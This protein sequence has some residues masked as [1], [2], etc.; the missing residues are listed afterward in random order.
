[1]QLTS[2]VI[3]L[4][5]VSSAIE[6][7]NQLAQVRAQGH[8]SNCCGC[9]T[10]C[11]Y[12]CNSC[13]DDHY[14]S[15]CGHDDEESSIGGGHHGSTDITGPAWIIC[16]ALSCPSF[17]DDGSVS[18]LITISMWADQG[19]T[20]FDGGDDCMDYCDFRET[21]ICMKDFGPF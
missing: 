14:D 21:W 10:N 18:A 11:C 19:F 20:I 4:A 17:T 12:D 6:F 3:V 2:I 13:C 16:D 15:D 5:G 7:T 9:Q 8:D 1:M